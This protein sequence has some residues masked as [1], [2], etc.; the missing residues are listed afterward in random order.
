MYFVFVK[1][2]K[3][4]IKLLYYCCHFIELTLDSSLSFLACGE[5]NLTLAVTQKQQKM[6]IVFAK[7]KHG[8]LSCTIAV[9]LLS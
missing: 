1:K 2:K 4:R 7:K 6:H 9:T 3:L 5:Y 8:E